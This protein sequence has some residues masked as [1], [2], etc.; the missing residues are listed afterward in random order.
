MVNLLLKKVVC[1]AN[2]MA[3]RFFCSDKD[4]SIN[5]ATK[6]IQG[7]YLRNLSTNLPWALV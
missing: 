4:S 3:T 7:V 5:H 2:T 1:K 6:K